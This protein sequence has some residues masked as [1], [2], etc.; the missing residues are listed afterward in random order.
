MLV[1]YLKKRRNAFADGTTT[2]CAAVPSVIVKTG[3]CMALAWTC[4][5]H[6]GASEAHILN[7]LQ[8]PTGILF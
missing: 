3:Q 1:P 8:Q 5:N 6:L 2:K 4:F 7:H